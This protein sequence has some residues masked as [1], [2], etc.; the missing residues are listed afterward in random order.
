MYQET[1]STKQQIDL[2]TRMMLDHLSRL[3]D[4][5]YD[6][7]MA[8]QLFLDCIDRATTPSTACVSFQEQPM[9]ALQRQST[10]NLRVV[11]PIAAEG[12]RAILDGGC[13]SGCHGEVWRQNAETK[14]KVMGLRP[15][16]L[17]RTATIFCGVGTSTT[18]GKLKIPMAIRPQESDMVILGCVHF[19]DSG[20]THRL[21]VS[22]R[23]RQSWA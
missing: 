11:D 21:F 2:A 22:R 3:S 9:H 16:W 4:G 7:S 15:F 19:T 23:V 1:T 12:V 20:E 5:N 10:Q 17:H 6:Q 8:I 13:N 14:M 18:S